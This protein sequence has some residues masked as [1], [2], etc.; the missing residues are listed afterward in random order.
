MYQQ[1]FDLTLKIH[2][3]GPDGDKPNPIFLLKHLTP[4]VYADSMSTD[5]VPSSGGNEPIKIETLNAIGSCHDY[6]FET[7]LPSFDCKLNFL[8]KMDFF[9]YDIIYRSLKTHRLVGSIRI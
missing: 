4:R 2:F 3:F 6:P 9:Y 1:F 8:S 5:I 7:K